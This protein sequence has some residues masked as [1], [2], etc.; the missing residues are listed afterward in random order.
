MP[1]EDI[2]GRILRL[3]GYS[4]YQT[5]FEEKT[6]TLTLWVRQAAPDPFYTCAGCG[7]DIRAQRRCG[8][9]G[10]GGCAEW[11]SLELV[12]RR[13]IMDSESASSCASK[14]KAT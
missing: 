13:R 8:A 9:L 12:Q 10:A 1:A 14:P 5:E 2:V 6:S 4:A 11:R 3:P 7:I